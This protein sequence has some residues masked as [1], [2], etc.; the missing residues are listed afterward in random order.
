MNDKIEETIDMAIK[1][2]NANADVKPFAMD[3]IKEFV[4]DAYGKDGENKLRMAAL[5]LYTLA[6]ANK[7]II[8]H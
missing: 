6:C 4:D 3:T 1:V 8:V 5:L 2:L 7:N